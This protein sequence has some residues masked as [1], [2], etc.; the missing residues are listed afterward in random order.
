MHQV[1]PRDLEAERQAV[2]EARAD[3]YSPLYD[4]DEALSEK[5]QADQVLG[6]LCL[7]INKVDKQEQRI[8]EL[9]SNGSN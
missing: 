9:E 6:M 8:K 3:I 4:E 7:L 5:L 2:T 1:L